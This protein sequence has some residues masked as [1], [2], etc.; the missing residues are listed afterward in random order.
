M[1]LLPRLALLSL[2]TTLA[3]CQT[4]KMKVDPQ[5]ADDQ[6][7]KVE[8]KGIFSGGDLRFG[9]FRAAGVD[10]GW[11]RSSSM[12]IVNHTD[13]KARQRY[14]FSFAAG[15]AVTDHVQC[16]TVYAETAH[17][18][19]RLRIDN[20]RHGLGCLL[21][22]ADGR[23]RGELVMVEHERH[24]PSGRMYLDRVAMDVIPRMRGEG[25]RWDM[26]EPVGYELR[27]D[28]NVVGAVQTIN[29][30]AV[31]IESSLPAELRQAAALASATLLLYQPLDG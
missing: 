3:A 17:Q 18:Y 28:G 9:E 5:L 14:E 25:A 10:R 15:A 31:W 27:I 20:G 13:T 6:R 19:G 21:I 30:G 29:G 16:E 22:A 26:V 11:T 12:T 8:R 2:V 23:S 7:M 24:R 1:H 4:M